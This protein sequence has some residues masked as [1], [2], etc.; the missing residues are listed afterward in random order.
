LVMRRVIGWSRRWL[1]RQ[2]LR[3]IQLALRVED[4]AAEELRERY[5][6][7]VEVGT[8][9]I[10]THIRPRKNQ[11]APA[12]KR[13]G[14]RAAHEPHVHE[15]RA[16]LVGRLQRTLRHSEIR[17]SPRGEECAGDLRIE[18]VPEVGLERRHVEPIGMQC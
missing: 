3:E 4:H 6:A 18:T 16:A 5:A 2:H 10:V 13:C 15:R 14:V 12:C 9:L 7:D 11:R 8:A 1:A 17:L